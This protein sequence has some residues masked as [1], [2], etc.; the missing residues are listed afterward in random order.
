MR[1]ALKNRGNTLLSKFKKEEKCVISLGMLPER[2]L[3][4]CG[5]ECQQSKM[6]VTSSDQKFNSSLQGLH[7]LESLFLG[8]F[9][10]VIIL[11]KCLAIPIFQTFTQA[12]FTSQRYSSE[13]TRQNS[14]LTRFHLH[15][16]FL[17]TL[18]SFSFKHPPFSLP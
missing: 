4:K 2:C 11:E 18:F 10:S 12:Y 5:I 1:Y 16:S 8:L 17:C 15:Q 9:H 3:E 7:L 14:C 13:Q 6:I